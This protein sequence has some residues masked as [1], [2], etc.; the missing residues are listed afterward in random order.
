M[1]SMRFKRRKKYIFGDHEVFFPGTNE[2]LTRMIPTCHFL[3]NSS[4][5]K[6]IK[7]KRFRSLVSFF[8]CHTFSRRVTS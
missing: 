3:S 7:W 6:Q 4:K 1:H 8:M 2:W 5:N